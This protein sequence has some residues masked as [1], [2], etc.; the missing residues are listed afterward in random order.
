[1]EEEE[2]RSQTALITMEDASLKD[3]ELD[4]DALVEALI[5]AASSEGV[6]ESNVFEFN[7][8]IEQKLI[9][10]KV[11]MLVYHHPACALHCVED[12]PEQPDR[13][14]VILDAIRAAN[15]LPEDAFVEAPRVEDE[16]VVLFH[17]VQMFD[18]LKRIMSAC[19]ELGKEHR[20][21]GDTSVMEYTKEAVY[22]AA[23]SIVAAVDDVFSRDID[24]V[25]CCVR[26]PGHH[27]TREKSMGFCFLSNAGIAAKYAY[28][29]Y[30][31]RVAV[32][33]FDVHH[34]NGTEDGFVHDEN[35]FYGSTHEK[36]NYPGTGEEPSV[37]ERESNPLYQRI[38]NRALPPGPASRSVFKKKWRE[39]IDKMILFRPELV[40]FSAGF[41]AHDSDPLAN[42]EL[43]ADDFAW[44][45]D[46]VL[47]ACVEI[48]ENNPPPCI[49]ILEGGYDLEAIAESAVAHV[50]S[51]LVGHPPSNHG[52]DEVQALKNYL[53]TVL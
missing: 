3:E 17:G 52:G 6:I 1:M 50:K 7:E 38:V 36:D 35:M 8:V 42:C 15:I 44:A 20:L 32:L 46:I 18:R 48:D 51:L 45:T 9:D 28:H 24:T 21:D 2:K 16:H 37:S 5:D 14:K 13:V 30:K 26:P 23:G 19:E 40:I 39:I 34:G 43:V 27:A 33:D 10:R 29:K 31:K 12:H 25:F 47:Q 49:S 22:R 41:D 53:D 4:M 11:K